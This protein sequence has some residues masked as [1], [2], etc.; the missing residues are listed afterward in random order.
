MLTISPILLALCGLLLTALSALLAG[1]V[2]WGRFA[3]ALERLRE[4]HQG[5]RADLKTAVDALSSVPVMRQRLDA[6]EGEVRDLRAAKHTQASA[7]TRLEAELEQ[8][9]RTADRATD[10]VHALTHTPMHGAPR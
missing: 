7:V 1:G 6:V 9:R 2:A 4:D 5:L 8:V 3:A 10:A